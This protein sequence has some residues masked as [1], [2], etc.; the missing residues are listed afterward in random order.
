[1]EEGCKGSGGKDKKL[2]SLKII[3]DIFLLLIGSRP[4]NCGIEFKRCAS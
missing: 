3:F 1:M 2:L 4:L